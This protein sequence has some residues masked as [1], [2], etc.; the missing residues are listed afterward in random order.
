MEESEN[1]TILCH[2]FNRSGGDMGFMGAGLEA[3]GIGNVAVSL[4]LTFR[5][6]DYCAGLLRERVLCA[7]KGFKAVDFVGHSMGGLVIR[8][9]INRFGIKRARRCVFIATPHLGSP[10]ARA[11]RLIPLYAR[12][13]KPINA[14]QPSTENSHL[15]AHAGVEIGVIWGS[16]NAALLGRLFLRGE[17]D[18]RVE[19]RSAWSADAKDAT[20][21]P[22]GHKEIHRKK[23]AVILTARFLRSGSFGSRGPTPA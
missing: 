4:P 13:V 7:A 16:R 9:C 1:I 11:V 2:G 18:G 14:L 3:L 6:L 8:A 5:S 23:E 20:A 15:I 19:A 17:S 21:L 12:V 10:I 22:F